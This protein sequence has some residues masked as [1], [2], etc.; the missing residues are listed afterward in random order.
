MLTV[1]TTRNP[2]HE[3]VSYGAPDWDQFGI[4]ADES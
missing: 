2:L 1:V 4:A 3:V